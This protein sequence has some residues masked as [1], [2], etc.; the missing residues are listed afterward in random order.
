VATQ[1]VGRWRL[2]FAISVVALAVL[3]AVAVTLWTS[4]SYNAALIVAGSILLA[5]ALSAQLFRYLG[6]RQEHAQED[7][8]LPRWVPN[9]SYLRKAADAIPDQVVLACLNEIAGQ[10]HRTSI[11]LVA[12]KESVARRSNIN[13]YLGIL[14]TLA[15]VGALLYFLPDMLGKTVA[16]ATPSGA[17]EKS[18]GPA[19]RTASDGTSASSKNLTTAQFLFSFLPR[20]T[21]ILVLELFA[22]FF[23]NLYRSMAEDVKY[24]HNELSNLDARCLAAKLAVINADNASFRQVIENLAATERN[25]ILREHE[26]TP[27][28]KRLQLEQMPLTALLRE[29]RELVQAAQSTNKQA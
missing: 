17:A 25:I 22:Y 21:L 11:R 5:S 20:V 1:R 10:Q 9:A 29:L 12:A 19:A 14:V 4:E 2:F 16:V 6:G 13:L 26:S 3:V 15:G 8:P 7:E 23:L 28:L 18:E 27:D 24:Y